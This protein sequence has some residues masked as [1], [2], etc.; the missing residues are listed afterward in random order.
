MA[1]L[2]LGLEGPL[3]AWGS[4]S[5]FGQRDTEREPTKSGLIGLL[6]AALGKPRKEEPQDGFPTLAELCALRL[7]V[8]VDR[9]G[10]VRRD[11]HTA[12]G[13]KWLGEDYGV[14]KA[15]GGKGDTVISDRFYL[16]DAVFLA[17]LE[18][19]ELLLQRLTEALASP[20]WPLFLGRKSFV[21]TRPVLLDSRVC[22]EKSWG[23]TVA[24]TP[25]LLTGERRLGKAPEHLRVVADWRNGDEGEPEA[26]RQDVPLSFELNA[27]RHGVRRVREYF[28]SLPGGKEASCT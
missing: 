4:H 7:A 16:A 13:G 18:G 22:N 20:V 3:Q 12:G 19:P 11:F 9:E 10:V 1:V 15:S 26:S 17:V 28:V 14:A 8:R 6:C 2:K 23:D 21:P 25:W 24:D 27:R 5:R